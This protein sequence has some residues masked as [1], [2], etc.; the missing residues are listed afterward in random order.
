MSLTMFSVAPAFVPSGKSAD[1]VDRLADSLSC[2]IG[3]LGFSLCI[4]HCWV[5]RSIGH[6]T[7]R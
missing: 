4:V 6:S 3:D 1:S 5:S 2:D 7:D